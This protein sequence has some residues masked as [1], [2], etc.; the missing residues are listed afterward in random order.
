VN[1]LAGAIERAIEA[2]GR[3]T[4]WLVPGVVGLTFAIVLLR[5]LFASGSIALQEAV[6]WGHSAVFLLGAA[7]ALKRD[8][9]VRVD[10]VYRALEP[11]RRA[12]AD[13]AG[14]LLF[15]LPVAAFM[16][17]ISLDYVAAAWAVREGSREPGGLP[18]VYLL[19][20]LIPVSAALL[21]LQGIALVLRQLT[22]LRG[23]PAKVE[24][25]A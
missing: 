20:T 24:E 3:A 21:L 15:L 17:W 10:I 16:L 12:L 4:S 11:R 18:G 6:L 23:A 9:H 19:K 1:A 2:I 13:L 5:Y 25:V 7:F 14:T 8:A 22:L